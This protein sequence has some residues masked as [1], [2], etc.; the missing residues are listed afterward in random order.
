MK[1]IPCVGGWQGCCLRKVINW[2]DEG[3]MKHGGAEAWEAASFDTNS[4]RAMVAAWSSSLYSISAVSSSLATLQGGESCS[5]CEMSTASAFS[6]TE[7]SVSVVAKGNEYY[8]SL[9]NLRRFGRP[10]DL[11][12]D[13][14]DHFHVISD[15][16]VILKRITVFS[17]VSIASKKESAFKET[18]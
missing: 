1:D 4:L 6:V 15:H 3:R 13:L 14:T 17:S 7:S 5:S 10:F 16:V 18:L 12:L 8:F 11:L 2:D 9:T